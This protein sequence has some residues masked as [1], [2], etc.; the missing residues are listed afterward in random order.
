MLYSLKDDRKAAD[1]RLRK[2][3]EKVDR[4]LQAARNAGDK[5]REVKELAAQVD[6]LTVRSRMIM[7]RREFNKGLISSTEASHMRYTS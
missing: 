7:L 6:K 2:E 5:D 3:Q 1:D 4:A